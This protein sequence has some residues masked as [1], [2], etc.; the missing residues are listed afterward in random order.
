MFGLP[1]L[2]VPLTAAAKGHQIAN[3]K[4]YAEQS[5]GAWVPEHD[6]ETEPLARLVAATLADFDALSA[7][8][9]RLHQMATP[10]AARMLVQECEALLDGMRRPEPR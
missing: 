10:D 5:G 4:I 1:A 3:A 7:Q 9:Q 2:V 8:T 6:W